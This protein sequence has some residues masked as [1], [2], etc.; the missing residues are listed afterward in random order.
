M[1]LAAGQAWVNTLC[2]GVSVLFTDS[3]KSAYKVKARATVANITGM[4]LQLISAAVL[5]G[6]LPRFQTKSTFD[7]S[8]SILLSECKSGGSQWGLGFSFH[9]NKHREAAGTWTHYKTQI[10]VMDLQPLLCGQHVFHFSPC[11]LRRQFTSARRGVA[12]QMTPTGLL[13]HDRR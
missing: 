13:E 10:E 2:E 7:F 8:A 5:C 4:Y 11:S 3:S 1:E 6:P 12:F 9:S